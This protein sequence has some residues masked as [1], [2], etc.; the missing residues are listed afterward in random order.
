M[1]ITPS[2]PVCLLVLLSSAWVSA[3]QAPTITVQPTNQYSLASSVLSFTAA[4]TGDA[5]LSYQWRKGGVKLVNGGKIGG[6]TT[7]TLTLTNV[8]TTEMGFYSLLVTNTSGSVTSAVVTL[9]LVP[10]AAW[11]N[12]DDGQTTI[13]AGLSNV[14]ALSGG[15]YHSLALTPA[16][17]VLAWGGFFFGV[18]NVPLGLSNVVAIAAG[19]DSSLALRADG[20]IV[21][22]GAFGTAVPSGLS[23]V[24][25]IAAGRNGNNLALGSDG[26]VTGWGGPAVPAGLMNVVAIAAADDGT[27]LAVRADGTLV[28]WDATG[29]SVGLSDIAAVAAGN[30]FYLA[31]RTNGT[32]VAW[33]DNS[34]GQT[35]VPAGLSN[36]VAVAAGAGFSIALCVDGTVVEWGNNVSGQSLVPPGLSNVVAVAAGGAHGLAL[37]GLPFGTA[38][39]QI[40]GPRFLIGTVDRPFL[41]RILSLNG[42]TGYS[43][44]GLPAGVTIDPVT[45]IISGKPLSAGNYAVVLWATNSLGIV[46]QTVTFAVNLPSPGFFPSPPVVVAGVG[47]NFSYTPPT[48]NEP[49]SFGVSGLPDGLTLDAASGTFAGVA[50]T[51]GD[52]PITIWATNSYGVGTGFFTLRV[53]PVLAWGQYYEGYPVDPSLVPA[54]LSNIVAVS[55]G[56][57]NSVALRTDGKVLM[58]GDGTYGWTN[59]PATLS[60]AVAVVPENTYT[61]ALLANGKVLEF[62]DTHPQGYPLE[63][64]VPGLSNVVSLASA[65]FGASLALRADGAVIAWGANTYGQTNV[66][67]GLNNVVAVAAGHD[68]S[69]ALRRNGTVAAWGDNSLHQTNVPAGLSNVVAIAA[70]FW[71]SIALRAD[72]TVAAWGDDQYMETAVPAG[73]SN[74]VAISTTGLHNL[75]LRADGTVVAWGWDGLGQTDVPAGLSNVVAIAAGQYHSLALLRQDNISDP[76]LE[77]VQAPPGIA[78]LGHGMPGISCQL[79]QATQLSG[80]WLP[81]VPVMFTNA[82]QT[83]FMTNPVDPIRFFRLRR[84]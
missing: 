72:G 34:Y 49:H 4:A 9:Q 79:Q 67:A 5:S 22:W 7:A 50:R 74:V 51:V 14:V 18:T 71:H 36:V 25:A 42:V 32:V 6:A 84:Q 3:Q 19:D 61:L 33:G 27:S 13:P 83:V 48:V 69:L 47:I 8:Q 80:P 38:A 52:F 17:K 16:G 15:S 54:G 57:N 30:G 41:N 75:A 73:L 24:V 65:Q 21:R 76:R 56:R 37:C 11:G 64:L 26:K 62:D 44:T 68:H 55:G 43:A 23:N 10:A 12:D 31:L 77:I 58:W 20:T 45:G 63:N 40:I 81:A 35:N 59:F 82:V 60:N 53:S 28:A 29:V 46:Q 70:G 2:T 39:P 1:K 78:L 66:P